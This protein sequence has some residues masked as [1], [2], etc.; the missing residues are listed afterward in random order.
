MIEPIPFDPHMD[1]GI[2]VVDADHRRLLDLVNQLL[3]HENRRE[4]EQAQALVEK[5]RAEAVA[6]FAHEEALMRDGGYWGLNRHHDDHVRLLKQ[7]DEYVARLK[8]RGFTW[9]AGTLALYMAD[10]LVHHIDG[11]D[12]RFGEWFAQQAARHKS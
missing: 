12:R 5:L 4:F 6:H 10:W 2:A 3:D 9:H 8:A 7:F 11:A 1:T